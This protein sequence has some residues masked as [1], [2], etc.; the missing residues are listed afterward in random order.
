MTLLDSL[1]HPIV[2]APLAGGASTPE[3]AAAVSEAGGLGFLAAG[4]K[5]ADAV[6]ADVATLRT[7][8]SRPF[9]LNVFA[10]PGAPADAD[11]VRAFAGTLRGESERAGVALGEPRHDDD[12]WEAKL[13]LAEAER[14]PLV[15]FTFGA[16]DAAVVAAA[17]RGGRRG[18]GDGDEPGRGGARARRGRR[19]ARRPGRRGRR[20]PRV[21]RGRRRGAPTSASSPRSS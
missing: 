6:R 20:A 2:Q 21:L 4:Y 13:A 9:G 15:T 5:S 8:T 18:V 16:P 10:P 14:L 11:A 1:E 12:G 17:A 3:L 19:R 7:L